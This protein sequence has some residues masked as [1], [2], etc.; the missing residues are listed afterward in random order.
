ME[1]ETRQPREPEDYMSMIVAAL[2]VNTPHDAWQWVED[3]KHVSVA[4]VFADKEG[5]AGF[6]RGIKVGTWLAISQSIGK[7]VEEATV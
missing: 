2:G 5:R 3:R 1:D 6:A 4:L 7:M